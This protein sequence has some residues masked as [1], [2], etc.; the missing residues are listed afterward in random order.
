MTRPVYAVGAMVCIAIAF[1]MVTSPDQS[2]MHA[3]D[4]EI[5]EI[6]PIVFPAEDKL[7]A[8]IDM[9][10][11]QKRDIDSIDAT[12]L[13]AIVEMESVKQRLVSLERA[14][15]EVPTLAEH[16]CSCDCSGRLDDIEK[17]LTAIELVRSSLSSSTVTSGGS[18]GSVSAK[19][20]SYKPRWQNFDGKSRIQH[21]IE[22]H[23]MDVRGKSQD[24][25]LR[26]LDAYHDQYGGGHP[27]Q[28]SSL[29]TN[30]PSSPV[31][32]S[33]SC[34]GGVCPTSPQLSSSS[35]NGWYLGKAF[36][37]RR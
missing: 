20:S 19:V 11:R 9:L 24:Q 28:M 37:R 7:D 12:A 6:K 8:I 4:A 3:Q 25:I 21:A 30:Y 23:G 22:D 34:P 18:S 1:L 35:S 27:V 15:M 26:E 17:R 5:V 2:R 36:G 14:S 32:Y 33:L 10:G 16:Q 31:V 13:N 29:P